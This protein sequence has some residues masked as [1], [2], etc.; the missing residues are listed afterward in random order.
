M[1]NRFADLWFW[2]PAS[3]TVAILPVPP[4]RLS[5]RV[6]V[7]ACIAGALQ[8]AANEFRWQMCRSPLL[9]V[10]SLRAALDMS[11]AGDLPVKRWRKAL[12]G[13]L[14]IATLVV[15]AIPSLVFPRVTTGSPLAWGGRA[16]GVLGGFEPRRDLYRRSQ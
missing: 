15:I 3:W 7:T 11:S 13:L 2:D 1:L 8:A 5:H 16:V 9:L 12:G 14:L 6:P 10:A 4:G